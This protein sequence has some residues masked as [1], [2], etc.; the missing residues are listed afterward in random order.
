[1]IGIHVRLIVCILVVL[2]CF[3]FT[4]TFMRLRPGSRRRECPGPNTIQLNTNSTLNKY[5]SQRARAYEVTSF[6]STDCELSTN[7][8]SRLLYSI[9]PR[10]RCSA[11]T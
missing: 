11:R 9:G 6:L 8:C 4:V 7:P 1:M 5:Q 2:I 3:T 10:F